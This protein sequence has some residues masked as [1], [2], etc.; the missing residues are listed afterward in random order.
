M[1]I[2]IHY[3]KLQSFRETHF[4]VCFDVMLSSLLQSSYLFLHAATLG[5]IP[6]F[7]VGSM[8]ER[9][10]RDLS[11]LVVVMQTLNHN[12]YINVDDTCI[13]MF[14]YAHRIKV[15]WKGRKTNKVDATTPT[16][17]LVKS[18]SRAE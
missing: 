4:L 16:D 15:V 9:A 10:N 5:R 3:L 7:C 2:A 13:S 14:S 18:S 8:S 1:L 6:G 12:L 11:S 17:L